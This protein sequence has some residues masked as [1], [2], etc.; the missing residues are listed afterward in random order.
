MIL[1]FQGEYRW[2]S[3]FW[4]ANITVDGV[5]YPSVE[6]A[7]VA[8][9]SP[10]EFKPVDLEWFLK[11][12]PAQVKR[13]GRMLTLRPDWEEIKLDV[14]LDL[15]RKK[16]SE[17]N[18]ALRELL[19]ET[20]DQYLEETNHWG[21]KFWG[22]CDGEGANWLGWTIMAVRDEIRQNSG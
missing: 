19:L 15:T 22:V 6:H 11:L 21:D 1:G 5:T 9:K 18:R 20:G 12:S 7:Y 13:V 17:D 14:M 8:A 16:Y 4:A 2:L 3:N 10:M